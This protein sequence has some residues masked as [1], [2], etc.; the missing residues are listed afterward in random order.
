[1]LTGYFR[2]SNLIN[3]GVDVAY[4]ICRHLPSIYVDTL[5]Q[6]VAKASKQ[7]QMQC[8]HKL[9]HLIENSSQFYGILFL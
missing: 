9:S 5:S 4:K 6:T 8:R 1:M 3:F 2:T 7:L